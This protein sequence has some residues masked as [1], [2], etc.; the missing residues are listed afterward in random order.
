MLG[1]EKKSTAKLQDPRTIR[2]IVKLD[3]RAR[4]S[5]RCSAAYIATDIVCAF[6][7]LTADGRILVNRARIECQSYKLTVEDAPS[8]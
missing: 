3:N 5:S 6:A 7:G 1:V 4:S 8:V 2:K